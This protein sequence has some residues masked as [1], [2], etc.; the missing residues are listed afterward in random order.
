MDVVK[1]LEVL[2]ASQLFG[3]IVARAICAQH[4]ELSVSGYTD[5]C[6]A[7]LFLAA[8]EMAVLG[9]IEAARLGAGK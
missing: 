8:K 4:P 5:A 9:N 1:E 7:E 2:R 6:S 3:E